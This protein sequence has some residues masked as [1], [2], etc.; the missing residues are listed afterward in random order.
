MWETGSNGCGTET[1]V[2]WFDRSRRV[3]EELF[4][5][6]LSVPFNGLQYIEVLV[7]VCLTISVKIYQKPL[8]TS[9]VCTILY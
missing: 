2:T 6:L 7:L 3:V 9:S 5:Y 8:K 1:Q 4:I